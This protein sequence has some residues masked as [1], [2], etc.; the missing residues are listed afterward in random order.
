MGELFIGEDE[1]F[2]RQPHFYAKNA[3]QITMR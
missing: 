2:N 1:Y 3:H